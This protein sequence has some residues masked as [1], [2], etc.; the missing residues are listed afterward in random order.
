MLKQ[1]HQARQFPVKPGKTVHNLEPP[2]FELTKAAEKS[3]E[4]TKI[5]L[6]EEEKKVVE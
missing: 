1:I 2:I 5:S 6:N 4:E 3:D